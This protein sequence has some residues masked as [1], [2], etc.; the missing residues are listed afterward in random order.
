M[1]IRFF[2]QYLL[3]KGKI[4]REQLLEAVDM[5]NKINLPLGSIAVDKGLLTSEEVKRIHNEQKRQ[6]KKFGEIALQFGY[7]TEKQLENLLKEQKESR[8]Y[9]G[10]ALVQC[11]HLTSEEL[12]EELSAFKREQEREEEEIKKLLSEVKDREVIE[13]FIDLT[14]KMFL[15][16]ARITVKIGGCIPYAESIIV[17][18]YTIEQMAKGDYNV[19]YI[20]NLPENILLHIASSMYKK[21]IKEVTKDILDATKEFINITTGNSCAKLSTMD[22]NLETYPPTIYNNKSGPGFKIEEKK[23]ITLIPL[24][25]PVGDFD[26]IFA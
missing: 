12:E 6:D 1:G 21:E 17:K 16:F 14:I 20:I 22:I 11:G 10:E 19:S 13:T 24:L 26:L 23:K 9:L 18:D 4:T 2:G 5:Q 8:I 25:S 15:R 7:L 3:Q